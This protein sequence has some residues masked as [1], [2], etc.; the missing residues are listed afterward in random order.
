MST[1][2]PGPASAPMPLKGPGRRNPWRLRELPRV[3][4]SHGLV[5]GTFALG[6]AAASA[7]IALNYPLREALALFACLLGGVAVILEP[8]VGIMAYFVLAFFRPQDLFWG[9]GDVRL[10]YLVTLATLGAL[11]VHLLLR[12]SLAFL[13][14]WETLF[15]LVLWASLHLSIEFGEF[16][17]PQPRWIGYYNKLF[18]VYFVILAV[19][20][21]TSM[22]FVLTGIIALSVGYLGWWA[23]EKYFFQGWYEVHGPGYT[24]RD[25][26]DFAM[27]MVMALPFMWAFARWFKNPFLKLGLLGLVP[28][29]AHGIMVTY[30]R[31]GFLGMA[32]VFAFLAWREKNKWVRTAMIV[33]GVGG[34]LSVAGANYT[35][36]I[37]TIENFEED[38]SAA[39]RL[40]S[41]ETGMRM[42]NAN[43][44][45][46]VGLRQYVF[47]YRYYVEDPSERAREAHNSWVQLVAECGYPA[48]I[49]YGLL[50]LAT[51]VSTFRVQRRLPQLPE[52]ARKRA[53][54]L[55]LAYQA[56]LLGYLICGFFLS[57]EDQEF[58]YL[59]VAMAQILDRLTA[60]EVRE[61][62]ARAPVESDPGTSPAPVAA[63]A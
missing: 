20:R 5:I 8:F 41:W 1:P 39:G 59:I 40:D 12:P 6:L 7:Y 46:G 62:V 45:F 27:L 61:A 26:N 31:G 30:S 49:A 21:S 14:R 37:G 33:G 48:V 55:N 50:V 57:M 29:T 17:A 15:L 22:L 38:K 52:A 24:L 32:V 47:G 51:I 2:E 56:S 18:L 35:S 58:F 4:L 25:R 10:T 44:V 28:M 54:A 34:F 9:L 19:T 16:G 60:A 42:A 11:G 36:R 63:S 3:A 53:E 43:P 13:K 23:N